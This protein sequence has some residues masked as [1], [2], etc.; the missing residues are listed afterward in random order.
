V[1]NAR[2]PDA[3]N[4]QIKNGAL[5][6]ALR[7]KY[8]GGAFYVLACQKHKPLDYICVIEAEKLDSVLR[9]RLCGKLMKGLPSKLQE[10]PEITATLINKVK[11]LSI[12]Q[13]NTE[14]PMFPM[15][16]T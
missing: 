5:V 6:S 13:W 10:L 14:Y 11:V 4:E 7:K 9:K 2:N 3:F 1:E 15:T 12:E 8:F 16:R